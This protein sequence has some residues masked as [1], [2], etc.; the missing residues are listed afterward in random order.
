MTTKDKV[1][2][3]VMPF[4]VMAAGVLLVVSGVVVRDV[5]A[6]MMHP[7]AASLLAALCVLGGL[8]VTGIYAMAL[9]TPAKEGEGE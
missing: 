6:G 8:V 7:E 3:L 5:F 2:L 1:K 4:A 9:T